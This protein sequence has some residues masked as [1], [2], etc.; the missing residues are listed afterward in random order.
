MPFCIRYDEWTGVEIVMNKKEVAEIKKLFQKDSAV[1]SKLALCYV[2][3]EKQIRYRSLV[4]YYSLSEEERFKYEDIFRKTLSGGMDRQLFSLPFSREAEQEGG[5]RDRLLALRGCSLSDE[6]LLE[7]F[8]RDIMETYRCDEHY[9]IILVDLVY[10]VPKK[11]SDRQLLEEGS[12]SVYHALLCSICPVRLS[13]PG[14][15]FNEQVMRITERVWDRVVDAPLHGFLFPSFRDRTADIH[16]VLYFTKKPEEGQEDFVGSLFDA[17][18]PRSALEKRE[19]I[20]TAI[21]RSLGEEANYETYVGIHENISQRLA[22]HDDGEEPLTLTKQDMMRILSEAGASP[23]AVLRYEQD[24]ETEKETEAVHLVSEKS[25]ELR[26]PGIVV[27]ADRDCL[28]LIKT[29]M[30]EGRK[31][32]VIQIDESLEVNGMP[33]RS[34]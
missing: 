6:S 23:E 12:D 25:F 18:I 10:D 5:A 7:S 20:Q 24:E 33:A 31:S 8:Y 29:A 26:R 30:V 4:S 2:D 15:S 27:K 14:L 22:E 3:N 32:L 11:T 9:F 21:G 1:F 16:E 17:P 34:L 28:H 13:K 19:Q